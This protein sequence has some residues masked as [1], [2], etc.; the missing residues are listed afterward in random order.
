MNISFDNG[1]THL[2][3]ANVG[4]SVGGVAVGYKILSATATQETTG[5][6]SG[7]D[8]AAGAIATFKGESE[9]STGL[10]GVEEKILTYP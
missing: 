3:T 1:V 7:S 9:T 4:T 2:W 10:T 8:Q 5:T 6:W